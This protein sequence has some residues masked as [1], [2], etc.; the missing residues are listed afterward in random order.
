MD[1]FLWFF[2]QDLMVLDDLISGM[3]REVPHERISAPDALSHFMSVAQKHPEVLKSL[4]LR[5]MRS[6]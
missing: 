1:G 3:I 6:S 2:T 4:G 5:Q